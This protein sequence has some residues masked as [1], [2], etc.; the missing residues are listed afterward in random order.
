MSLV[1]YHTNG[2]T[3]L[4][5]VDTVDLSVP[6]PPPVLPT[7]TFTSTSTH[8]PNSTSEE[9]PASPPQPNTT[10]STFDWTQLPHPLPPPPG[11]WPSLPFP[12]Q[13]FLYGYH[14]HNALAREVERQLSL[15]PSTRTR[16]SRLLVGVMNDGSV[17]GRDSMDVR[18][19]MLRDM[20]MGAEYASEQGV[21]MRGAVM[22]VDGSFGGGGEGGVMA[23]DV[24]RGMGS[25]I[26][27]AMAGSAAGGAYHNGVGVEHDYETEALLAQMENKAYFPERIGEWK[28]ERDAVR[29]STVQAGGFGGQEESAAAGLERRYGRVEQSNEQSGHD[30]LEGFAKTVVKVSKRRGEGDD[31]MNLG[32]GLKFWKGRRKH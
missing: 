3:Q 21:G 10:P 19:E 17:Q 14:A 24:V 5:T 7:P 29:E 15:E 28:A 31:E 27:D 2:N 11:P 22:G 20:E 26:G 32:C 13:C 16:A 6:L 30:A 8:L 4:Y 9:P 12:A 1:T 23:R 25:G 18:L